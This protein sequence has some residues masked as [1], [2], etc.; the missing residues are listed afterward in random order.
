[1][2]HSL[3]AGNHAIDV[4]IGRRHAIAPYS[5]GHVGPKLQRVLL[6]LL[7]FALRQ[8]QSADEAIAHHACDWGTLIVFPGD[9]IHHEIGHRLEILRHP[10]RSRSRTLLSTW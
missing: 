1:M 3:A 4:P 10:D 6:G 9:V 8:A 7:P 2:N 5:S